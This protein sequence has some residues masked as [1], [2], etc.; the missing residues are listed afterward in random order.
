M[1]GLFSPRNLGLTFDQIRDKDMA[2]S[3]TKQ[4]MVIFRQS[5]H[6]GQA[7]KESEGSWIMV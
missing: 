5:D 3:I 4:V 6:F 7:Q 2:I 1:E